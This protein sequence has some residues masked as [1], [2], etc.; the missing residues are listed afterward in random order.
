VLK[1][2]FKTGL[3]RHLQPGGNFGNAR[4]RGNTCNHPGNGRER[5][6]QENAKEASRECHL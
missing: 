1:A 4:S 6:C 2:I 3:G 5:T